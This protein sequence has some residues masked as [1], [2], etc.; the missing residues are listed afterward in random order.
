MTVTFID[1]N[2]FNHYRFAIRRQ[3]TYTVIT[4]LLP[5]LLH[6]YYS[7]YY[8]VITAV[9]TQ[10][11]LQ[12]LHSYYRSYYR[13]NIFPPKYFPAKTTERSRTLSKVDFYWSNYCIQKFSHKTIFFASP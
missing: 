2:Y 3:A 5:Q 9:I 1:N 8:T 12:L 13:Q 7:S 6:S 4:Q 10:L 11:L